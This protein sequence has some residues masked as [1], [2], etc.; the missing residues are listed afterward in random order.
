MLGEEMASAN[1]AKPSVLQGVDLQQQIAGQVIL[2][3][4]RTASRIG[5]V[6]RA[7]QRVER[8]ALRA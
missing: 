3:L 4:H 2:V 5:H 8:G 6:G 7:A 1:T